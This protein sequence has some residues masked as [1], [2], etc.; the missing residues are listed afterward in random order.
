M[1]DH[2]IG[3]DEAQA[4]DQEA[5]QDNPITG[6]VIS[7]QDDPQHPGKVVARL[8]DGAEEPHTLVGDILDAVRMQLP[9]DLE[10][11]DLRLS[12][13]PEVTEVWLAPPIPDCE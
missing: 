12:D 7:T 3:S 1:S 5:R 4:A 9:A 10:R 11:F 6:W 13:P 8:I 2:V